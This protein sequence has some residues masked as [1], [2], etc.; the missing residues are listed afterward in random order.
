LLLALPQK[1]RACTST[2]ALRQQQLQQLAAAALTAAITVSSCNVSCRQPRNAAAAAAGFVKSQQWASQ[3]GFQPKLLT[4]QLMQ[5]QQV[6]QLQQLWQ[7]HQSD[8]NAVHFSALMHQLS[9]LHN[10][11]AVQQ[12]VQPQQQQQARRSQPSRSKQQQ[13]SEVADAAQEPAASVAVVAATYAAESSDAQ[14]AELEEELLHLVEA[15]SSS[16]SAGSEL[17]P[18]QQQQQVLSQGQQQ[19]QQRLVRPSQPN[20]Q[21]WEQQKLRRQQ[22]SAQQLAQA[23]AAAALSP[24]TREQLDARAVVMISHALAKVGLQDQQ[25]LSRIVQ[26]TG[27]EGDLLQKLDAQQLCNLIWSVAVCVD[28]VNGVNGT[29]IMQSAWAAPGSRKLAA[30]QQSSQQ[31]GSA[32][33]N[34][35]SSS[36]LQQYELPRAWLGAVSRAFQA[37][38]AGC[39]TAGLTMALWGLSRLRPMPGRWLRAF[40]EQ[41]GGQLAQFSCHELAVV[42]YALGKLKAEVRLTALGNSSNSSSRSAGPYSIPRGVNSAVG[43]L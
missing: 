21:Q 32:A 29:D 22:Q 42:V 12:P 27:P 37:K 30:V 11:A 35:S 36:S 13:S 43:I 7:Q 33:T 28:A 14:Y 41:S 20:T 17:P 15:L 2:L 25:L 26:A 10:A 40:F 6:E 34:S 4:R 38:V 8:F 23:V 24:G 1:Q 9:V 19:Q 18:P 31:Q 39:S 3:D 16:S 5:A